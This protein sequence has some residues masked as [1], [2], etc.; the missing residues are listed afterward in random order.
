[1]HRAFHA[2]TLRVFKEP[3][4]IPVSTLE[5][6]PQGLHGYV[7]TE[8]IP[9]ADDIADGL[10]AVVDPDGSSLGGLLD[11]SQLVPDPG[12]GEELDGREFGERD[13]GI[14]AYG[15]LDLWRL[16]GTDAMHREGCS[17]AK[18]SARDSPLEIDKLG[19]SIARCKGIEAALEAYEGAG[20]DEL[21]KIARVK[22][23]GPELLSP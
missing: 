7:D 11:D 2:K 17:Q 12:E 21:G 13:A 8:G 15:E 18:D 23:F 6:L 5:V 16:P 3:G 20:F 9:E 19:A 10:L 14:P 1:M 4:N 22:A